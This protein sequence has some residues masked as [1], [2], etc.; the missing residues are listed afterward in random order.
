[1]IPRGSFLAAGSSNFET[2][3]VAKNGRTFLEVNKTLVN[4]S[5][6]F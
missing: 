4:Y 1:M 6:F 2:V 3:K 5:L